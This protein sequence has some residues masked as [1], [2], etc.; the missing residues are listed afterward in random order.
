MNKIKIKL[1]V[2]LLKNIHNYYLFT[3]IYQIKK[4]VC[5][6]SCCDKESWAK[7]A[8][9]IKTHIQMLLSQLGIWVFKIK[10]CSYFCNFSL[11]Y[12]SPTSLKCV[13]ALTHTLNKIKQ[14]FSHANLFF[15]S[16]FISD[17]SAQKFELSFVVA[18]ILQFAPETNKV[19]FRF[20]AV[21]T[22]RFKMA[23]RLVNFFLCKA[24]V[25]LIYK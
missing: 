15:I 25:F 12:F 23:G 19:F 3:H 17:K 9:F 24:S 4:N 14:I 13:W 5:K 2:F 8:A 6:N 16:P 7:I 21:A 11:Y 18:T 10:S 20:L 1:H 22:I